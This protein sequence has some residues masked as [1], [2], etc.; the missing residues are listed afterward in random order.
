MSDRRILYIV[1]E[2]ASGMRPYASTI[3]NT[4]LGENSRAIIV[5]RDEKSKDSYLSL[6]QQNIVYINYPK[7]KLSRLF[8]HFYPHVLIREIKDAIKSHG[9]ELVYTLTAE[10]SLAYVANFL[11]RKVCVLHTVHDAINHDVKYKNVFERLKDNILV[12]IPNKEII[13]KAQNLV[14][15]SKPQLEYL[16]NIFPQKKVFYVPFPT[17]V[18]EEIKGGTKTVKELESVNDYI[19]FFGSVNLYKGVH[20]L[21]NL[22]INNKH[23][24]GGRKLV[25]AGAGNDYFGDIQDNDV[26]RINRYIDDSEV[27]YLFENA[28]IVVYPYISATQSG[29]LSIA[30]YFGKKILLSKTPF[31]ES[32]VKGSKAVVLADVTN[33]KE[34]ED[35]ILNLLNTRAESYD[36]Y[37]EIYNDSV[38]KR[39]IEKI[40]EEV[41]HCNSIK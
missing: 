29:V 15:N 13:R 41:L 19:L 35:C 3:L 22:Y 5:V 17:L 9:I 31:F 30:T 21:Y 4:I 36:L 1:S 25:I 34:F 23:K 7:G 8:W 27:R 28:A 40:Q 26:I 37:E 33:E 11:F 24:F 18:N 20:L 39:N 12:R 14:T 2:D 16:Q 32:E 38:L 10:I 6:P